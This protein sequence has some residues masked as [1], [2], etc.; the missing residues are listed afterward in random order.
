MTKKIS[1]NIYTY[2]SAIIYSVII[3][4]SFLFGKIA[5]RNTD[6][7]NILAHRFTVSFIFMSLFFLIGR[8]KI[9]ISK[10]DFF[11]I[12]PLAIFNPILFFGFQMF[13]LNLISSSEAGIIQ[14][15]IP[16]FTFL[17]A[18]YFLGEKAN[19][20]QEISL[21]LSVVGVIYI[22][23]NTGVSFK[24]NST[25]GIIFILISTFSSACYI[26]MARKKTEKYSTLEL[27]Y[28]M[29]FCG[30]VLFNILSI[31]QRA[32][33]GNLPTYFSAFT[34]TS[35]VVSILYLGILSS[36][37][38]SVLSNFVLSKIEASKMSVFG[39]LSTLI[40]MFAG[41]ILLNE[42]LYFYH[43]I[44]AILIIVGILGTNKN[45]K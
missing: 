5:L 1:E 4:F 15:M 12:L 14:A 24:S 19:F 9:K 25:I 26:V 29:I 31:S 13:G 44:G 30:M 21:I 39:N 22:F 36:V 45:K 37:V 10:N 28:V 33:L 3:G 40:T 41:V 20:L 11:S 7:L 43:I 35:F 17:L 27:S 32:Y 38:T 18:K 42:R 2:S 16:I 8:L 34:S 6:P 23:I